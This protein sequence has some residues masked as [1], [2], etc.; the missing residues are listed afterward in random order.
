MHVC[1]RVFLVIV[2]FIND[3]KYKF[4]ATFLWSFTIIIFSTMIIVVTI[5]EMKLWCV[6]IE[7]KNDQ[8]IVINDKSETKETSVCSSKCAAV[9]R[10]YTPKKELNIMCL[11]SEWLDPHICVLLHLC[12]LQTEPF[13]CDAICGANAE[14][15]RIRIRFC[16]RWNVH[17]GKIIQILFS[18][19][20]V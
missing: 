9:W 15:I 18:P 14:C 4:I 8:K 12:G 7:K 6:K 20:Y 10:A 3:E 5:I 11:K 17:F 2:I 19:S 13:Q 1:V 16:V